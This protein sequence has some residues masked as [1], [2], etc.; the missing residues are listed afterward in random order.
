MVTVALC[1]EWNS[2]NLGDA[3]IGLSTG[4]LLKKII[5]GL[6]VM[7]SDLSG[8]I[9]KASTGGSA[10]FL[11]KANRYLFYRSSF[12]RRAMTTALW[13]IK[14]KWKV[15]STWEEAVSHSDLCIVGGGHLLKDNDLDFPRK[16]NSFVKLAGKYG[17]K[18]CFWGCGVGEHHWSKGALRLFSESFRSKNVA[19]IYLRD[20]GSRAFITAL[21]P[22]VTDKLV[23]SHDPALWSSETFHISRYPRSR[24]VGL[25]VTD[26]NTLKRIG[27]EPNNIDSALLFWEEVASMLYK[28]KYEF[29]FFTNGHP[30]DFALALRAAD[31]VGEKLRIKDRALIF[32]RPLEAV[33]LVRQISR[34]GAIA[35]YRTHA[36]VIAFSLGIPSVGLIIDEKLR[37]FGEDTARSRFFLGGDNIKPETIVDRLIE[38]MEMKFDKKQLA[39]MKN[40]TENH[41][42]E[43]LQKNIGLQIRSQ[44]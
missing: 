18:V 21:L 22:E 2:P 32:E 12:Y 42:R 11:K 30:D 44:Y 7:E 8:R 41:M 16:I 38:A 40:L 39:S 9:K 17:K 23:S 33:D 31:H 5:P 36:N 24:L 34:F 37:Q 35:A 4:Y 19:A 10:R 13:T 27:K 25:G 20:P 1:G 43:M 28:Q 26:P 29:V 3:V 15:L 14:Y 6:K